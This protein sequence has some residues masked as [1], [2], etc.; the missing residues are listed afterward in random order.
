[1]SYEGRGG[2]YDFEDDEDEGYALASMP[3]STPE[4]D[5]NGQPDFV[6]ALNKCVPRSAHNV[7]TKQF[8]S[9]SSYSDRTPLINQN[10]SNYFVIRF[11]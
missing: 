5:L 8:N 9:N 7:Y 10:N 1:M 3:R 2:E 4:A 11:L 6:T